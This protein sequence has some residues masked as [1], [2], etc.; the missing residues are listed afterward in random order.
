M[1]RL[2]AVRTKEEAEKVPEDQAV[3]VIITDEDEV[4]P[5]QELADGQQTE[6]VSSKEDKADRSDGQ[7][8]SNQGDDRASQQDDLRKRLEDLEKA[9][10][11]ARESLASRQRELDDANRRAKQYEDDLAAA[12]GEASSS[13]MDAVNNAIAAS[14]AESD[15]AQRDYEAAIANQDTKAQADAQRRL[16]RAEAR[17]V[18]YED[19]KAILE[20][21]AKR[22]EAEPK[23]EKPS[24]PVEA[25][26]ANLPDAAKSWLREHK[27]YLTEPRKNAKIQSLHWDAIEAGNQAFSP[28]YFEWLEVQLGM[29]EAP[30]KRD[31]DV[32]DEPR[33]DRVV[34]SAPVSRE[35]P[36]LR[37]G[38][39][40]STRITLSPEQREAAR[41]SGISEIEYAKQLIRLQEA[42][43]SGLIQ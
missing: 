13:Q 10:K 24:D 7:S 43:K 18:Q 31:D 29:R 14:Q 27:E 8:A 11:A 20:E 16:S 19:S 34:T 39:P 36:S 17:L 12:K 42:K 23:R 35:S 32:D 30:R 2:R 9:E 33:K 25:A 1:P 6:K 22:A 38:R 4:T 15:A 37:D 40:T 41:N 5:K 28:S 21:R 3:S 26:I